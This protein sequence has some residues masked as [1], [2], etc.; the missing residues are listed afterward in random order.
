MVIFALSVAVQHNN[1]VN[2]NILQIF[3]IPVQGNLI[4]VGMEVFLFF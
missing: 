4:G 2:A 1:L 3:W